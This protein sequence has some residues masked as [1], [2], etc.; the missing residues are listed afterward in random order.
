MR[1][2][3]LLIYTE[4]RNEIEKSLKRMYLKRVQEMF[5]RTLNIESIFNIFDEVFHGLSQ[6]SL[7]SENLYSFYESLKYKKIR[8]F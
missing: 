5:K 3:K 1:I 4:P 2:R 6:A 7:V 8:D